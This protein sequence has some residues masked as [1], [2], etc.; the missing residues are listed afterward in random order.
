MTRRQI[1]NVERLST[2][3][4]CD[5]SRVRVTYDG[6]PGLAITVHDDGSFIEWLGDCEQ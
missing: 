2:C 6:T 4:Q 5:K 3:P 1:I